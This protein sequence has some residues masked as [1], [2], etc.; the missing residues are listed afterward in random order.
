[1]IVIDT[2]EEMLK[3]V[4]VACLKVLSQRMPEL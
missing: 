4:V 3:E 1:M 2:L